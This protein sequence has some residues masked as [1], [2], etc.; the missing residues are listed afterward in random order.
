MKS[1]YIYLFLLFFVGCKK[2]EVTF[3]TSSSINVVNAAI[4]ITAI[5]VNPSNKSINYAKTT[6]VVAYGTSKFYFSELGQQTLTAV[7]TADTTK[8]LFSNNFNSEGGFHTLYLAGQ[9]PNIDTL[10]RREV[11]FPFIKTDV[12]TPA[13]EDNVTTLRFVN[14]SPN[15]PALKINIRNSTTNEVDNFSYKSISEWKRYM[16]KAATTTIFEIRNASTNALLLTYTFG[17]SATNKF[18][19]VALVIKGLVGGT[20]TNAFG[21]FPVNYF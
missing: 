11:N 2:D 8:V 9:A 19:N 10:F 17:A 7:S 4:D 3:K 15:S 12:T 16:N 6:D 5:K 14:L 21:V 18:K 1:L 20:G 13:I